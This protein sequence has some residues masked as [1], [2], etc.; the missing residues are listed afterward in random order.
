MAA[1]LWVS[2]D[3][4]ARGGLFGTMWRMPSSRRSSAATAGPALDRHRRPLPARSSAWACWRSPS[5][6]RPATPRAPAPTSRRRATS[7]AAGDVESARGQRAERAPPRRP[8][9]GRDAGH[10]RRRLEP[11]ARRRRAGLGRTPPGQ[12]PRPPD[13][14]RRGGGARRGRP[15]TASEATLFGDRSVDVPTLRTLVGAV[16]EASLHLDAA[17]L[18][19]GEVNDS[20]HRGRHPPGG[21]ARR[22]D[23]G[24]RAR[25]PPAPAARS[26]WQ[27]RCPTSS[28][29]RASAPTS[30]PCSTPASSASPAARR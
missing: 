7:L 9:A 8:G 19:L 3:R 12:R 4:W 11:G 29:P 20:A 14:G 21:R 22:G 13:H 2:T 16:D 18:E 5:S 6:R 17:Q 24:R 25:S 27:R 10:R 1:T 15:S 26:R 28:A 30:W 23:R